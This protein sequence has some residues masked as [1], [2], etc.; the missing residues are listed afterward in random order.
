MKN[1]IVSLFVAM[2]TASVLL[3]SCSSAPTSKDEYL[4][5]YA[6][7]MEDLKANKEN[8]T[9]EE[10]K[11]KDKAFEKFSKELYAEFENDLGLGEQIK[12]GKHAF[13][14]ATMRGTSALKNVNE[15]GELKNAINEIKG[16]INGDEFKDA[17]KEFKSVWND[18]MKGEF[19]TALDELKTVWDGDLKEQLGSSLDEVKTALEDADLE[20]EIN[21][22]IKELEEVMED[23]DIKNSVKDI[24]GQLK[25]V[26]EEAEAE[27]EK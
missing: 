2:V 1:N 20:I 23:E 24:I 19:E 16:A 11:E 5:E 7:F 26:L 14:Y 13:Q 22:K 9:E 21:G 6:T 27:L 17:I 12:I 8:I 25:E 4:K 3:L 10:W 18:D 15:S